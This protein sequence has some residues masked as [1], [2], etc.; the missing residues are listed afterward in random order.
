MESKYFLELIKL[1]RPAYL[2]PSSNIIVSNLLHE[3]DKNSETSRTNKKLDTKSTILFLD[4]MKN[5]EKD[6]ILAVVR[7][8][9]ENSLSFLKL[10]TV[11]LET[12]IHEILNEALEL[13]RTKF[14]GNVYTVVTNELSL[15][16]PNSDLWII[17]CNIE[18]ANLIATS[19]INNVTFEQI[20]SILNTFQKDGYIINVEK[21]NDGKISTDR[22]DIYWKNHFYTYSTY[23]EN[24][25]VLRQKIAE[26]SIKCNL[27][28][29]TLLYDELFNNTIE[30]LKD[31]YKLIIK[32]IEKLENVNFFIGDAIQYWIELLDSAPE[33]LRLKINLHE[34][35][36]KP[37]VSITA[38]LLHPLYKGQSLSQ[39]DMTIANGFLIDNL[40]ED[41][42]CQFTDYMNNKGV[43]SKL[44]QKKI[45]SPI[46]FWKIA[47]QEASSLSR[48]AL[49]V[50]SI[51]T[52]SIKIKDNCLERENL[53]DENLEKLLNLYYNLK[54]QETKV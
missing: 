18:I 28:N 11:M 3:M 16:N 8:T 45:K 5:V 9:K 47:E 39:A 7:D 27:S 40:E 21:I 43:F 37:P 35:S 30:E 2:P 52:S 34:K 25:M 48:F 17:P 42:L 33:K 53:S 51:P 54:I 6:S 14:Y 31:M 29:T 4:R 36:L 13:I 1:L 10:F 26:G 49:Q 38:N 15:L 50:S 22:N 24:L 41:G 46:V 20:Q 44:F 19:L 32:L 12:G 23:L